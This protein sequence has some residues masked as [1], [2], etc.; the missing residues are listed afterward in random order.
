MYDAVV[1]ARATSRSR[2]GC[3]GRRGTG[4]ARARA[5]SGCRR[6]RRAAASTRDGEAPLGVARRRSITDIV[7]PGNDIR[8]V[9]G[10]TRR[11]V[12]ARSASTR[13]ASGG[14]RRGVARDHDEVPDPGAHLVV[15]ARTPV[16]LLP[17]D[18]PDVVAGQLAHGGAARSR[19]RGLLRPEVSGSR[20]FFLG[21]RPHAP[22]RS[23]RERRERRTDLRGSSF[24]PGP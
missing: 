11:A 5:P 1:E 20:R 23:R 17:A 13:C 3:S 4:S 21:I 8:E 16:R 2:A 9:R 7:D 24:A 6:R 22:G 14:A 19:R 15:A 18:L 12:G 10:D